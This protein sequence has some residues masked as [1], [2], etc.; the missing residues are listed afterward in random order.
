VPAQWIETRLIPIDELQPF[1]GN[2]RRG[3]IKVIQESLQRNGQ[4]RSLVV[5]QVG[6]GLVV[7][8]GNQTMQALLA[9]GR[10]EARCEI[11]ACSD[12]EARRINLVDNRANDL[13]TDDPEALALL[14]AEIGD[15]L[16]GTGFSAAEV[17]KM[18]GGSGG[19]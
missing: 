15:D 14:L 19:G 4:Y 12:S 10:T 1:P 9:D 11:I 3:R 18:L 6:E 7:L 8:A 13:S 2:A 17:E 5:R 16:P